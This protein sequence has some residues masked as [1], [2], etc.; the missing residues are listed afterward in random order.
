MYTPQSYS[1]SLAIWDDTVTSYLPPDTSERQ[2]RPA[3][4]QSERLVLDLPTPEKWK[5]QLIYRRWLATYKDGIPAHRQ[6]PIPV[7]T[8]PDI[9]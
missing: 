3:K 5:T 8:G 2:A 9:E 1:T 4:P 7:L 6:S